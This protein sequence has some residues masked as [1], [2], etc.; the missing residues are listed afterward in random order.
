MGAQSTAVL[1]I[2]DNDGG[3]TVRFVRFSSATYNVNESGTGVAVTVMRGGST[4]GTVKVNVRTTDTGTAEGGA[5]PCGPGMDFTTANP[6]L[7]FNPGE[8]SKSVTI[9]L[10]PDT[11]VDGLE[12]IGLELDNVE[13]ATLGTPNTATV[14][15][16]ENDVAGAAQFTV[17]ASSVSETQGTANVLVTRSGGNASEVEVHWTITGGTAVHGGAPGSGVDY[18]GPT[19][20][21]V[22]FGLNEVSRSI[23][24]P[25]WPRAGAQGPRSVT[26]LLDGTAGGGTLGARTATTLW[27]LDAD[28]PDAD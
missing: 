23:P 8:T 22:V 17:A 5:G 4:G 28:I 14:Q 6:Q 21:V 9:P 2:L 19:S 27:I 12:T 3:A 1:E 7:T 25:V 26:L 18:T 10:C 20:G 13:G 16:A 15:I 24:I 11:V